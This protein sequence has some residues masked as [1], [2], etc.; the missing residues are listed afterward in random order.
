MDVSRRTFFKTGIAGA[1]GISVFG[2][3]LQP[4]LARPKPEDSRTTET[5]SACHVL[6]RELRRH[7]P[8]HRG[9]EERH[10]AGGARR[11]RS[12]SSHQP[13]TLCPKGA[14][15]QQDIQNDRRLLKPQV[16]RPGSDH[17]EDISWDQAIDEIAQLVKKT[18]DE[19]FIETGSR[20]AIRSTAAN[21]SPSPAAAPIPTSSITWS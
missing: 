17:W 9:G 6:R 13:R 3:D 1:V 16:R 20:R 19:T 15:L 10:A 5:R 4:I 12:R 8:H 14:S 11:R 18:R 2:F 7:H 21:R